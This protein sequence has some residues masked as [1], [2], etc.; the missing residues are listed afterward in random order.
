MWEAPLWQI[1]N[2]AEVRT[3]AVYTARSDGSRKVGL[4][5]QKGDGWG[6][7]VLLSQPDALQ[8]V[9]KT[10]IGAQGVEGRFDPQSGELVGTVLESLVQ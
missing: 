1:V 6:Q 3:C 10:W 7:P 5:K 4:G 2:F 8:K 9:D